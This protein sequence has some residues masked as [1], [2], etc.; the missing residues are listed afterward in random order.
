MSGPDII[1]ILRARGLTS[2]VTIEPYEGQGGA[3]PRY[4]APVEVEAFVDAKRRKVRNSLGEEVVSE[5]TVYCALGTD[6]PEKSRVT[7]GGR[8]GYV[9]ASKRHDGA[10]LPVP[11]HL[12]MGLT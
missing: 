5:S 7:A 12:E 6:A 11:D 9:I 2:T 8:V 10:G 1:A 4:G 3:G